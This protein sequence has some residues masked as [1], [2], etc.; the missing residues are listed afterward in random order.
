MADSTS[1]QEGNNVDPS[2]SQ[3]VSSQGS[4]APVSESSFTSWLTDTPRMCVQEAEE[5]CFDDNINVPLSR[6]ER[7]HLKRLTCSNPSIS[8]YTHSTGSSDRRW[9]YIDSQDNR[10]RRPRHSDSIYN[11][12]PDD[13][14]ESDVD[15]DDGDD[16]DEDDNED[17]DDDNDVD[18]E[19]DNDD[20]DD[21]DKEE[22]DEVEYK[23]DNE[24]DMKGDKTC[25][26]APGRDSKD[27]CI[28]LENAVIAGGGVPD[29]DMVPLAGPRVRR[30]AVR[31]G[32]RVMRG[33]RVR[34]GGARHRD[35]G[36]GALGGHAGVV[37]M[38]SNDIRA[39]W[40]LAAQ[41]VEAAARYV[42]LDDEIDAFLQ[43][44][45]GND[46]LQPHP[47]RQQKERDYAL[48]EHEHNPRVETIRMKR[49]PLV[50]DMALQPQPAVDM[51]SRGKFVEHYVHE[52][53]E[54][55]TLASLDDT[56]AAWMTYEQARPIVKEPRGRTHNSWSKMPWESRI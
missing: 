34:N 46:S 15:N 7:R 35:A 20:D 26:R 48:Q 8:W 41:K 24:N 6:E 18:D 14:N 51:E 19:D 28:T 53:N 29:V 49:G 10:V 25:N 5:P 23:I 21:D 55:K 9:G 42:G 47:Q 44:L 38:T 45:V 43:I 13:V 56:V 11:N 27:L 1:G 36:V 54:R 31:G 12:D 52:R 3:P 16:E 22:D 32:E 50:E 4:N 37:A 33:R 40:P 2:L 39:A 30:P 17:E